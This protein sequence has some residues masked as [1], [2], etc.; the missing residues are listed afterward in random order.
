MITTY[1]DT[2]ALAKWYLNEE[3]SEE[4]EVFVQSLPSAVIS[5]LTE[6]EF[7]CLLA[8]R[9]R[10]G[11]LTPNLE[12]QIYDCFRRDI[13]RGHLRL[14]PLQD[15]H[16]E[17]ALG[18]IDRLSGNALRTLD[19]LHLA[20]A[21]DSGTQMLATADRAMAKAAEALGLNVE[22]FFSEA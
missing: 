21:Q 4:F 3:F 2:S 7:R 17:V 8:R 5:S 11:E 16:L 14:L 10:Y 12:P 9:R 1:L 18:L 13:A 20:L 22:R 15:H 19:A 6:L